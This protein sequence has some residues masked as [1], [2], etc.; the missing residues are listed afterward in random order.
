MPEAIR[1]LRCAACGARDAGPRILCPSC[2]GA[3]FDIEKVP[4]TGTLVSWTVIRRPPAGMEAG[5]PYAVA[6][7][8]LDAGVTVTGRLLGAQESIQ[9]GARVACITQGK[10]GPEFRATGGTHG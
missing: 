5:G 4:G 6:V 3:E 1:V 2:H 8:W 7:V 10:H 9:P